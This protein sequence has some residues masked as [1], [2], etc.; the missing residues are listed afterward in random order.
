MTSPAAPA[1]SLCAIPS[2]YQSRAGQMRKTFHGGV[3]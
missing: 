3:A 1:L 2:R